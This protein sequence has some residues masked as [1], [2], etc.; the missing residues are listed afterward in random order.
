MH[1]ASLLRIISCV[2]SAC[3]KR[4]H[5]EKMAVFYEDMLAGKI[6]DYFLLNEHGIIFWHNFKW[7]MVS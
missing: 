4:A 2:T 5:T 6:N 3:L 1:C 7:H